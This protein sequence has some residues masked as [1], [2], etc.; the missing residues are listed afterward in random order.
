M[1]LTACLLPTVFG[2]PLVP[3]SRPKLSPD[4]HRR[5]F[6]SPQLTRAMPG[7]IIMLSP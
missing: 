7:S 2:W 3:Y 5:W 1:T 4:L 6:E